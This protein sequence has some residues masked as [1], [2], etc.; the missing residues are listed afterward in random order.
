M[1][2]SKPAIPHFSSSSPNFLARPRISASVASMCLIKFGVF[3]CCESS[4]KASS[5]VIFTF[6]H[7]GKNHCFPDRFIHKD[8]EKSFRHAETRSRRHAVFQCFH[9]IFVQLLG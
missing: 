1:S 3:T 8:R 7:R 6:F 4:A 2:C 5:L 9:K